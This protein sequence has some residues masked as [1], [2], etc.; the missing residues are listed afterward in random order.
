MKTFKEFFQRFPDEQ[1]CLDHFISTRIQNGLKCKNCGSTDYLW[2]E[3]QLVFKCRSCT[4][5]ISYKSGTVM[6]K[7]KLTLLDWYTAMFLMT[8]T[9]KSFS[10]YEMQRQLGRKRYE[11]V[12]RMMHKIRSVMGQRDDQY[13]LEYEVELD[14][15]YFKTVQPHRPYEPPKRG[16]GSQKQTSVLVM[17]E[18]FVVDKSSSHKKAYKCRYFKM[19]VLQSVSSINV[20]SMVDESMAFETNV[21]SDALPAFNNIEQEV[22]VHD[23]QTIPPKEQGE[24]LPWV[25]TAI[26]NAKRT[27]LGVYHRIDGDYLQCYLDEFSYKLNR[28][29]FTCIFDRIIDAALSIRWNQFCLG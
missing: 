16:R 22:L 6:H 7:S 23:Q 12:F 9:K 4:S 19:K 26:A 10:S 27:L 20:N 14:D 17:A 2:I 5:K 13:R 8:S 29:Y 21:I 3:K 18:S 25:H 24:L 1:S 15:A 28:R 11:P